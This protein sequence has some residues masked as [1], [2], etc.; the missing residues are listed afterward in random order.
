MVF[1][2]DGP[3]YSTKFVTFTTSLSESCFSDVT[4]VSSDK[5]GD[6]C[7]ETNHFGDDVYIAVGI[8]NTEKASSSDI[9]D[10]GDERLSLS[11]AV[12]KKEISTGILLEGNGERGGKSTKLSI[13]MGL[14]PSSCSVT[15]GTK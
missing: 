4:T 10:D 6:R 2:R 5:S 7:S 11:H 3:L 9:S 1:E 14:V 13:L 15:N 8:S 12:D